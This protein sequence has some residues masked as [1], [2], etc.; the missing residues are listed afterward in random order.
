MIPTVQPEEYS[1][2]TEEKLSEYM[3]CV[4]GESATMVYLSKSQ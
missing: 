1:I 2:C 3:E 4:K